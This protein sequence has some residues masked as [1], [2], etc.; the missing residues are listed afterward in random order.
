M[1]DL[2][3]LAIKV[4]NGDVVKATTANA[5]RAAGQDKDMGT[6]EAG[7]LANLA[8]LSKN[9]LDDVRNFRSVVLTVKRGRAFQ[10]ADFRP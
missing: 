4:E 9:P 5:A 6:V 8:V 10:R 2:A 3:T 7:K 1:A